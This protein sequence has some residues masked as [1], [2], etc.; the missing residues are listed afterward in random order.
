MPRA[1]YARLQDEYQDA[2]GRHLRATDAYLGE[3]HAI[4]AKVYERLGLWP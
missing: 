2:L 3:V 4:I 1:T